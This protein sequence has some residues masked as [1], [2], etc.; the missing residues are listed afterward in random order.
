MKKIQEQVNKMAEKINIEQALQEY[1]ILHTPSNLSWKQYLVKDVYSHSNVLDCD[2]QERIRYINRLK[3]SHV[4]ICQN[5]RT[6][7]GRV[8][9]LS[10]VMSLV[11]N[12]ARKK[13]SKLNREVVYG[14]SEET[15][16][17]GQGTFDLWNGFQM[18]DID[19]KADN[20]EQLAVEM[21][22]YLFEKLKNFNWFFLVAV[23]NSGTGIHILTKIQVPDEVPSRKILY[24]CNYRH[25]YS[26][27]YL[28]LKPFILE[29]GFTTNDLVAWMDQHMMKPQQATCITCDPNAKISTR[30]FEDF[31][32]VDFNNVTDIDDKEI[33]WITHPELREVFSKWTWFDKE[34]RPVEPLVA[35]SELPSFDT[36]NRFH[37]KHNERWR[38]AN[39]LVSI[40][41]VNGACE[42]MRRIC[43]EDIP[44]KELQADCRTA[45][46]YDKPVDEWA[47]HR[48]NAYH[49][50]KI[51]L[52]KPVEE[53]SDTYNTVINLENPLV[54]G[55]N[56]NVINFHLKS[57]EYLGSIRQQLKQNFGH[58]TLI[59]AGAGLGK[60]E[61]I[62]SFVRD[63]SK[64]MM[65]MP[66]TSTIK[67]KVES[68]KDW[69]YS[70]ANKKPD[71]DAHGLALTVD[72]FSHLNPMDIK[73]A[74]FDYVFIDESHLLFMSEYR[75][76]M[77]KVIEL[78]RQLEIPVIFT[79]GT[80][81]AESIFFPELRYIK[82]TKDDTRKK[83]FTVFIT[84]SEEDCLYHLCKNMAED[85]RNGKKILFPT[86]AG[87]LY[88]KKVTTLLQHFLDTDEIIVNYYKKSNNGEEFMN[89][90]NFDKSI[91]NSDVLMC[92][93]FLSVGVDIKDDYEF[94][95][96]V[97]DIWMPQELEQ[98]ANRLRG[99]DLH[100]KMFLSDTK[101][102]GE[103][104]KL[105]S[106]KPYNPKLNT[107]ELKDMHSILRLCNASI[108][109]NPL[110]YK[111]NSLINSII[112]TNKFVELNE[113]DN[114][115]YF[116]DIAYKVTFFERKYREY[117]QQLMVLYNAMR[118]Y[119]YQCND[120]DVALIDK[121]ATDDQTYAT[122]L[123]DAKLQRQ[124]TVAEQSELADELLDIITEERIRIYKDVMEGRY[125]IKKGNMWSED[126]F[127][128]TMTVKDIEVFE[129]VVPTFVSMVKR[130]SIR[131]I[132]DMFD[133]CKDKKGNYNWADLRRLKTLITIK[134]YAK[135][136]QIDI[137]ID[138]YMRHI[139]EFIEGNNKRTKTEIDAFVISETLNL[140]KNDSAG[141]VDITRSMITIET[142][143]NHLT[144]LFDVLVS[145][146]L[147]RGK[148]NSAY[149][150][151]KR[152]LLWK[153]REEEHA[154]MME[155]N[156]YIIEQFFPEFVD[157]VASTQHIVD[158]V[159]SHQQE[160]D[161]AQSAQTE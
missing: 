11:T 104:R 117:V 19:I 140:A 100:I 75:P 98:F 120:I 161:D 63:G 101:S 138:V 22:D 44:F 70:Y 108:E 27:I 59:D 32:Y 139:D 152:E 110:D 72:K 118:H 84:H 155:R 125:E 94:A 103:S 90:I 41:G 148:R 131:A 119:G 48:L 14:V 160:V 36:K 151:S 153:E 158:A 121:H 74:G 12:E 46:N 10:D 49:G 54:I 145:K 52:N 42:V 91:A 2:V 149:K 86:N 107:D 95:I 126:P 124:K 26:F 159:E 37:Y 62:K 76:V 58:I 157:A 65:V 61:M 13:V 136:N 68:D 80:P 96:Y 132:R 142:I 127:D 71:L 23:S 69:S 137:P 129:K 97:N 73:I 33:A 16:P 106:F 78:V 20:R 141:K 99:N 57:D 25:K 7:S 28:L 77:A 130:Y 83:D 112:S 133:Y 60:T 114:K 38:L 67:S 85:I 34:E 40:C 135:Q 30:F 92:S 24:Y 8:C 122:A 88:Q 18:I 146:S 147:T 156:K 21:R 105:M 87:T 89:S 64:V 17:T 134:H 9:D 45:A 82:V 35:T 31:I 143:K 109:R 4:L 55:A 81:V 93:T 29:K 43:T 47:V 111:Y 115:Y 6:Q 79:T 123:T 56:T 51:K 53:H 15:R 154:E 116:N 3:D 5:V 66:F 113:V 128:M 39:T 150:L 144:K 1:A 50:F 102:D